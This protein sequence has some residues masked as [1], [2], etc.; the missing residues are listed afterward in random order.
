M[1][2]ILAK[3]RDDLPAILEGKDPMGTGRTTLSRRN[4]VDARGHWAAN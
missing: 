4:K 2:E 3:F 1:D